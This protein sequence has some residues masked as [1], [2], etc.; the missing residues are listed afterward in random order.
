MPASEQSATGNGDGDGS[1]G[2][3]VSRRELLTAVG[4]ATAA[5]AIAPGTTTAT[6]DASRVRVRI[7]PGPVPAH[8]WAHA[9]VAGMH[10]DW[11]VPYRDAA[12]A[13]ETAL[14]HVLAYAHRRS[15]LEDLEIAA[16]RG[17][18]V[19]FPLSAAPRSSEAVV[20]SLSTVLEVFGDR[21][22]ERNA[23]T[24]RTA[25]VLFCWSPFNFRVGYGG[26]LSP[27]AEVGSTADG[28][29]GDDENGSVDGALTVAN[30]GASEIW[31]SRAVT[32]NMAIHETLHTFLSPGVVE[33]VGGTACDH[34][35]GAAVRA[36][37]GE[38]MR[39]TPM[40]T[41]YAGPDRLGGGT[42]FHGRGCHDHDDF[43]RHDGTDG[44]ENWTY[45]VEPSEATLEAVT[46]YLERTVER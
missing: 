39:V 30:L 46:R 34:E 24:E 31:D 12:A 23:L 27:N 33:A 22:R 4:G 29:V 38:T 8:G 28:D 37:D 18:R 20:P 16:E 9:G 41:A 26:T 21:L 44:V 19:R 32:R 2:R 1:A 15:R 5:S 10:R 25:H 11:P 13:I 43:H 40:A 14:D 42:R 7:Y 17:E 45:T 6:V 36:D 3:L 35:L